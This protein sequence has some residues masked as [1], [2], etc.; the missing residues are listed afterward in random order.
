[1]IDFEI[2]E[3]GRLK[4]A[5]GTEEHASDIVRL[6]YSIDRRLLEMEQRLIPAQ[7][8]EKHEQSEES[9][10]LKEDDTVVG[11]GG[12][13]RILINTA[14]LEELTILPTITNE[15]AQKIIDGRPYS[16]LMAVKKILKGLD[17]EKISSL[18]TLE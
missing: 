10:V 1:M 16:S 12:R 18:M 3:N 5:N 4:R 2:T 15:I 8:E 9:P 17:W 13:Q 11:G 6:L 7:L 14:S